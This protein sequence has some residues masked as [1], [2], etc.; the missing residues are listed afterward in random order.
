MVTCN[1]KAFLHCEAMEEMGFTELE[2][3]LENKVNCLV[4]QY[5]QYQH[6]KAEDEAEFKEAA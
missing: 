6:P 4:S 2:N 3:K 5:L 1:S